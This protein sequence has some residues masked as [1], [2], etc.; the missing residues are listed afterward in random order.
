MLWLK[1][2]EAFHEIEKIILTHIRKTNYT[3]SFF[4]FF[5]KK[6]KIYQKK[7]ISI[8]P[9]IEFKYVS[10]LLPGTKSYQIKWH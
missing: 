2:L 1:I 9:N 4:I 8:F 6:P 7:L 3:Q 10:F 5:N